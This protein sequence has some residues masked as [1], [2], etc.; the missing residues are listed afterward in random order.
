MV[1]FNHTPDWKNTQVL[2]TENH[3]HKRQIRE[4][5][6]IRKH[7]N[8]MNR[9]EGAYKLSNIYNQLIVP[10]TTGRGRP[11]TSGAAVYNIN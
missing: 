1:K 8:N 4:A 9:E 5:I 7:G 10:G 2:Q 6:W 11:T 3:R